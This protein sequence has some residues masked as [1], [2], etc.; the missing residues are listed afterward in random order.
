MT[1]GSPWK[2]PRRGKVRRKVGP[3]LE[4]SPGQQEALTPMHE[5]VILGGGPAGTGPLVWAARNG[6][7][8]SWLDGGIALVERT[9]RLGGSLGLYPLNADSRGTSFLECL[10]GPLCEPFLADVRADPVT[11]ELARFRDSQPTLRLV[12]R[13]EQRVGAAILAEFANHPN[14][15]AYTE[16]KALAVQRERDGSVAVL[17]ATPEGERAVIRAA[18]AV[19]ALGGRPVS[20]WS[21]VDLAPGLDLGRWRGKIVSSHRLLTHGGA[22]EVVRRLARR[23][24]NPRVMILGSAHSA[25]SAAWMLLDQIP[26]LEFGPH[27]VQILYR[28]E[29]R[30]TYKSREA[31]RA[32]YYE[33]SE[34]DVC[35][36]TGRVHRLGGLQGDGREVWR[37]IHSKPGA[38]QEERAIARPLGSLSRMD[39]IEVLD[40]ADLIIPALGYRMASL[41]IYDEDGVRILLAGHGPAVGPDCRLLTADGTPLP[42]VFGVGLGS[43]FVPWGSMSGEAS[44]SGQQNSLW[45]FQNGLGE[46]IYDNTRQLAQCLLAV[47]SEPV[48]FLA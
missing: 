25:F 45:L 19:I 35:Q 3:D 34:T 13:F 15:R 14:S 16:T 8:G 39:L 7:L 44:F 32:D 31:A 37:R 27:G 33:F 28:T 47:K 48:P 21:K 36:A 41:P 18:S 9:A 23:S 17:I 11:R 24:R 12:D 6:Q 42:N 20:A 10:D 2:L 22:E 46:M 29:P 43:D 38:K 5:T 4:A 40:K 1:I 26:E 30:P